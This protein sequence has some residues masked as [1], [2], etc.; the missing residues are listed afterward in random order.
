MSLLNRQDN[1]VFSLL[2]VFNSC[3]SCYLFLLLLLLSA[4][5]ET[6]DI[7]LLTVRRLTGLLV[8]GRTDTVGFF[9]VRNSLRLWWVSMLFFS[10]VFVRAWLT[11]LGSIRSLF[12]FG[13][14]SNYNAVIGEFCVSIYFITFV[15]YG[16]FQGRFS[17]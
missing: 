3:H 2:Y 10:E 8:K 5:S 11:Y 12:L 1:I 7:M 9:L 13:M 4:Y 6:V 17:K 16:L 15:K 14:L